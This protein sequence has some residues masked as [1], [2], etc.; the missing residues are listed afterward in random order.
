MKTVTPTELRANIYKLLEEVLNT[1]I[2]IE[3]NKGN[4]RLRIAPVEKADKLKN[5]ISRPHIIQGDPD[6]LVDISWEKE[7]NLDLP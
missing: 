1:G 5:L 6:D 7:V 2:P 3:V 4:R